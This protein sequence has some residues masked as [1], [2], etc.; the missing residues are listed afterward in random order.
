MLFAKQ[1]SH[2]RTLSMYTGV[3]AL[4]R[5][6]LAFS[7]T[8]AAAL[9]TFSQSGWKPGPDR[10][11]VVK[12]L[13]DPDVSF[14]GK[15]YL[16][17]GSWGPSGNK[18]IKIWRT[19]DLGK[20]FSAATYDPSKVDRKH[21]YCRI[22][23]PDISHTTTESTITFSAMQYEEGGE[24][25]C[26]NCLR[27]QQ[28]V[29]TWTATA[30]LG[31]LD[32]GTPQPINAGTRLPRTHNPRACPPEGCNHAIR[33][34]SA[35]YRGALGDWFL[36][37]WFKDGNNVAAFPLNRPEAVRNILIPLT[38]YANPL[39]DATYEERINE[40]P[41]VF[42]RNGRSYLVY[43]RGST[44]RSYG[45]SYLMSDDSFDFSKSDGVYSL[46]TP[47][48]SET[49][50][51]CVNGDGKGNFRREP[52]VENMG[53]SSVIERGGNYYIY[54]H[55]GRWR[56]ENCAGLERK[57]NRQQLRFRPDGT[58][59][60]LTDLFLV[61]SRMPGRYYSLDVKL[62]DGT[63]I[64]PCVSSAILGQTPSYRFTGV[65]ASANNRLVHKSEIE[66]VRL[67]HSADNR[68][69]D[70]KGEGARSFAY[71]GGEY[72][73]LEDESKGSA[74]VSFTWTETGRANERFTLDLVRGNNS[75]ISP[76]ADEDTM[77][78]AH[79]FRFDGVCPSQP[80]GAVDVARIKW[81][82]LCST[83]AWRNIG[84]A[85]TICKRVPFDQT[86][87]RIHMDM[88]GG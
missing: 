67:A 82:R 15:R 69:T 29:T 77:G 73:L 9:P 11:V 14:D 62:K 13:G 30:P 60:S 19:P 38:N 35:T 59:E 74:P 42:M 78:R 33:I 41:D 37:T 36:Y 24:C 43:S 58:I 52:L 23:A 3:P 18:I 49:G 21:D 75:I 84:P 64:K 80:G 22:W 44:Q 76:C 71:D 85:T 17:T 20:V 48:F 26:L 54:F 6:A 7:L 79:A 12:G 34:D 27:G 70:G 10:T 32:F 66:T 83:S 88:G 57:V 4:L 47:V 86:A 61:W 55:V 1:S 81:V 25:P 46:S 65:C 2:R 51:G 87:K 8:I 39:S 28:D 31:S 63:W 56:G 50:P 16:L 45:L 68:W 40:A 72:L 5:L 53:H